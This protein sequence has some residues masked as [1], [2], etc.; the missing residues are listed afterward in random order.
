MPIPRDSDQPLLLTT[1]MPRFNLI[2]NQAIGL[3]SD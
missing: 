3:L 1:Y 2:R